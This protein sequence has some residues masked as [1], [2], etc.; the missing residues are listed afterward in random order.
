MVT[1]YMPFE[2]LTWYWHTAWIGTWLKTGD[3]KQFKLRGQLW[4]INNEFKNVKMET[5]PGWVGNS[6]KMKNICYEYG[7]RNGKK[8]LF[9]KHSK[10]ELIDIIH[11]FDAKFKRSSQIWCARVAENNYELY[12]GMR[13]AGSRRNNFRGSDYFRSLGNCLIFPGALEKQLCTMK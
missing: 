9:E 1:W 10:G 5:F 3:L 13:K 4:S 2:T 6:G 8:G 7:R 12:I 11:V